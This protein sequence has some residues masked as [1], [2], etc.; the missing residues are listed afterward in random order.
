MESNIE[1]MIWD[2]FEY[3]WEVGYN[4]AYEYYMNNNNL[5]VPYKYKSP[6]GYKLGNWIFNQ[7]HRK[8]PDKSYRGKLLT[9][10]QIKR[11]DEIGM[12]W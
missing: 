9:E 4:H 2:H 6:D 11:L 10:E 3:D 7:R 12:I 5:M 1:E 8:T